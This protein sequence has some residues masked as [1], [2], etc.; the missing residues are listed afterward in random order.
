MGKPCGGSFITCSGTP[1]ESPHVLVADSMLLPLTTLANSICTTS[2]LPTSPLGLYIGGNIYGVMA[3]PSGLPFQTLGSLTPP[4]S[5]LFLFN[6]HSSFC[7]ATGTRP[8]QAWVVPRLGLPHE[9]QS[10]PFRIREEKLP[11]VYFSRHGESRADLKA[12]LSSRATILPHLPCRGAQSRAPYVSKLSQAAPGSGWGTSE[13]NRA[14][15]TPPSNLHCSH[16]SVG[17]GLRILRSGPS[18]GGGIIPF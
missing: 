8:E 12:E 14:R 1:R 17:Q 7:L 3:L 16:G 13:Q 6:Q 2:A 18:M 10:M 15:R 9:Q 11:T 5:H 4:N